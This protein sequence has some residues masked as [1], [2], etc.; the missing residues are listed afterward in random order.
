MATATIAV[1]RWNTK[2]RGMAL[3]TS[4]RARVGIIVA[5]VTSGRDSMSRY[6]PT[7]NEVEEEALRSH[8]RA[9]AED[10]YPE[11]QGYETVFDWRKRQLKE[12]TEGFASLNDYDREPF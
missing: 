3:K 6:E 4:R 11:G 1:R 2:H 5:N 7:R 10:A 12:I 9:E 8:R